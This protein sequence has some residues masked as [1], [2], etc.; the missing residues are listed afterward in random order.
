MQIKAKQLSQ[1][2]QSAGHNTKMKRKELKEKIMLSKAKTLIGYKLDG[3]DGEIGKVIEFY[4]D[5]RHWTIRYL[6]ADTGNWLTGRQVL[7]SPYALVA[8]NNEER[9]IV[10]ELTR[11]Q[12][13]DSPS[14]DSDKPV[15]RQF[16]GAY[17]G[18]YGWPVYWS[19]TYMWGDYP[20]IVRDREKWKP[21]AG[22]EKSWDPN[23]RST[24]HVS[25]YAIHATDGEIGHVEDFLIDDKTW[26][27]RYLIV[28][29]K[30]WRKGQ[31]VIVS[32]KWIESVSWSESTVFVN[33]SRESIKQSPEFTEESLLTRDYETRLHGHYNRQGY[34]VDEQANKEHSH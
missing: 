3:I 12:I 20:N 19:G 34:W 17:Y 30:N 15:S 25:G 18:Y 28:D 7:I 10:I 2:P 11:K 21:T 16:E 29:T 32:T 4:F 26:A 8:V 5:A 24:A 33:L 6:V 14:L 9:K 31:K 13:E 27:I 23:L 1:G 22:D